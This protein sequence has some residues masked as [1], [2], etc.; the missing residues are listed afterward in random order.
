[1][2]TSVEHLATYRFIF[3]RGVNRWAQHVLLGR[4][5]I[6]SS[7]VSFPLVFGWMYFTMGENGLYT[8]V[9]FGI[10]LT[11]V[12]AEQTF[13]IDALGGIDDEI[14]IYA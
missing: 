11:Q 8:V 12:K 1:M 2:Q 9:A 14:G 7:C 3:K 13:T 4:G 6:L 10:N 5:S